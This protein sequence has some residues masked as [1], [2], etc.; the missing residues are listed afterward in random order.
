M[1][2]WTD[3]HNLTYYTHPQKLT[4]RQVRWVVELMEYDLKLQH[5]K[6]SKMVVADVLSQ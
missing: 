4:R 3:H 5:K 6:G 1:I 2:V